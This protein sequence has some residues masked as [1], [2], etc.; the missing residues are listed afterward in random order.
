MSS[1]P[2]IRLLDKKETYSLI[3][4][5]IYASEA[6]PAYRLLSDLMYM[7]DDETFKSFLTLFEGQTIKVPTMQMLSQMLTALMTYTYRDIQGRDWHEVAKLVG[8]EDTPARPFRGTDK[9]KEL[10]KNIKEK[11]ITVGGVFDD[12]PTKS[13]T[14]N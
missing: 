10:V 4:S 1:K 14:V 7:M 9:Y 6:D 11:K 2:D 13:C 5:A 3:L 8:F 12:F